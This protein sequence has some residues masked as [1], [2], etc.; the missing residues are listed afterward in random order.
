M[1]QRCDL[2]LSPDA[3]AQRERL[4]E[5]FEDSWRRGQRPDIDAYL[6]A[7]ARG[8]SLLPDLVHADLEFRA[9]GREAIRVEAYF[10]RYPELP[11]D[12]ET[13]VTLIAR[14]YDLRRRYEHDVSLDEYLYRFPDFADELR[15]RLPAALSGTSTLPAAGTH[16]PMS[17]IPVPERSDADYLPAIPG[18]E[19]LDKLGH[20]SMGVVYKARQ[21]ALKRTVAIKMMLAR[22]YASPE[23]CERF[24]SEAEA[25]ARLQH[26]NIV[27]I[28][29]VGE[30]DGNLY[31]ALEFA[32]GGNLGDR[33]HGEPQPQA[34][35]AKFVET[36]A[37]A[38]Q[39]AHDH[40]IVHRDLKP[41]NVLLQKSEASS[42][43]S[44][45]RTS[46]STSS[47]F[48]LL[49]SDFSLKVADFGLAKCLDADQEQTSSGA[50]IGSPLYMAP[51]QAAGA[52]RAIGPAADIYA[53]GVILYEMFTGRV[54]FRGTTVGQTLELV[55]TQEPL[56]PS[57][58]QPA[59]PRDLETICLKCL[60]KEPH[61]RYASAQALADDLRRFRQGEPIQAR[62]VSQVERTV[63]WLR[64]RP[65]LGA[66]IGVCL[67]AACGLLGLGAQLWF[68]SQLLQITV[69]H[70]HETEYKRG[71]QLYAADA[72]ML[73]I[74]WKNGNVRA[75]QPLLDR[76]VPETEKTPD[77]RGFEWHYFHR[78]AHSSETTK[79]GAA[80]GKV[81]GA[82]FSTDGLTLATAGQTGTVQLWDTATWRVR[83]TLRGHTAP[84]R[85]LAFLTDGK[86][87]A[88]S[89]D[90]HSVRLWDLANYQERTKITQ[91]LERA[92]L[93]QVSP[94]GSLLTAT[95]PDQTV[96]VWEAATGKKIDDVVHGATEEIA[97][98]AFSRLGSTL[99]IGVRNGS[100]RLRDVPK[101]ED[102]G[103]FRLSSEVQAVAFSPAGWL[104][105]AASHDGFIRV[106]H[107]L[108][109]DD[110][111]L[112]ALG[113]GN[114]T[115][116]VDEMRLH[117]GGVRSLAFAL[118]NETVA[119]GGDDGTIRLRN[120]RLRT[121]G[122]VLRGHT[123]PVQALAFSPDGR[124]LVSSSADG[125]LRRW[126]LTQQA[127][128][129][130]L[131]TPLQ[132]AGPMALDH[133][134]KT[135]AVAS[136]DRTIQIVDPATGEVKKAWPAC[137]GEIRSLALT[138]DGQTLAT[139]S[140]DLTMR[141]WKLAEGKEE[142]RW[143]L[144]APPSCVAF[145]ADGKRLAVGLVS[146]A[147]L[148]W[149][150]ATGTEQ[151]ELQGHRVPINDVA[152]SP[153]G[154]GLAT[155]DGENT[156]TLWNLAT[157]AVRQK[158]P[159]PADPRQ[160][161]FAHK[162]PMLAVALNGSSEVYL[163][164]TVTAQPLPKLKGTPGPNDVIEHLEFSPDDRL[165]AV[166][167]ASS[168][169]VW[170][171][172]KRAL[173][174]ETRIRP[175]NVRRV[176][177]TPD[178]NTLAAVTLDGVLRFWDLNRG[179]FRKPA[180]QPLGPVQ[181][182][183][184]T[185]DGRTLVTGC[186]P[187]S[188][189][190]RR[191][192]DTILGKGATDR[193]ALE[194]DDLRR[195]DTA[196]GKELPRLPAQA[197]LG[198]HSLALPSDH[199]TLLAGSRGGTVW[200]WNLTT[201]QP[202]PL[203]FFSAKHEDYWRG[204]E[205]LQ[206]AS[207]LDIMPKYQTTVVALAVSPDGKT[208]A[209]AG[210]DGSVQLGDLAAGKFHTVLPK[211]YDQVACLAFTPDGAMM[212]VNDGGDV[213]L[214]VVATGQTRLRL[215]GNKEAI[216][217]LAISADGKML[218]TGAKDR[219]IHLWNLADPVKQE[220]FG[221]TDRVAAVAFSPDGRTLASGSWDGTVRLWHVATAQELATL[222]GHSGRV[223][224]VAFSPQ[225]SILA[226]GGDT[227]SGGGEVY[228]WRAGP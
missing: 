36:L 198:V 127:D 167:D 217:C 48:C 196:T 159:H 74:H 224:A 136:K 97:G 83:Q 219:R 16:T 46:R 123:E 75:M 37:R 66:L 103:L 60:R 79:L 89:S 189:E 124:T 134:G 53:L 30:H 4:I 41:T 195:W 228:L 225:G 31:C 58:L 115:W 39:H 73:A 7:E 109:G 17:A 52:V 14:E 173:L 133:A 114:R 8:S 153:D 205:R 69:E 140:L 62:P 63:K 158:L 64:Q 10:L 101:G 56:P 204:I 135:L 218:A 209:A 82:A 121:S 175:Q 212:A 163:W 126:D 155:A 207:P 110:L 193:L 87:L 76:H 43:Q 1:T 21:V 227:S 170:N 81:Y 100:V 184:F 38:I 113:Y 171:V 131:T 105:A 44:Q 203:L 28:Y 144:S 129:Q 221:H 77:H 151:P 78:L 59:L 6:P 197:M 146:G 142:R 15:R 40:R 34:E 117:A 192:Y 98:L 88:T 49:T 90:D 102:F 84:V 152:F 13:A 96:R 166:A 176:A 148:Q 108:G 120:Y 183:G 20:G 206:L 137:A 149:D 130:S 61:Q 216:C 139:V 91:N 51:E 45:G 99:A 199:R 143:S 54:P 132:P 226:S 208:F 47:D 215:F 150:M 116:L 19:I 141:L 112:W 106:Y 18:Y 29:E 35:V 168:L 160:L 65:V 191:H 220:L 85:W 72:R 138:P 180:G 187:G 70:L 3:W 214:W 92:T 222:E 2:D 94:D 186:N 201:R 118:D 182:L 5:S 223:N 119:A 161:V 104:C 122:S 57:R 210:D 181:A 95:L 27:Q 55:Q 190:F 107:R 172:R 26:P 12:R 179:Q 165:L 213:E 42:Q 200:S 145:S 162:S 128:R 202:R 86:T 22:Q 147:V 164:D 9:Q 156:V 25:V 178:G 93:A 194:P 23:Q 154:T 11:L 125:T 211:K 80:D 111:N 185:P 68:K 67:M 177:F 50:I 169:A 24:R 33:L 32:D 188:F 174:H 157:G 71:Q